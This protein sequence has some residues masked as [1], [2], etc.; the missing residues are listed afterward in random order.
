ME[1]TDDGGMK[2]RLARGVRH[3]APGEAGDTA[4]SPP[5]APGMKKPTITLLGLLH[6]PWSESR[7]TTRYPAM[8]G[9]GNGELVSHLLHECAGRVSVAPRIK[10]DQVLLLAAQKEKRRK[11]TNRDIATKAASRN[12]RSAETKISEEAMFK[13]GR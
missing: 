9:K 11:A 1:E 6:L 2:V 7:L 4:P 3:Q 5:A 8:A 12:W 13:I 10:L